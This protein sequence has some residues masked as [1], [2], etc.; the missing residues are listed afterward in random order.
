MKT[1]LRKSAFLTIVLFI[2]NMV[3]ANAAFGQATV[4]T[5]LL[6]YPP[7]S[8]AIITGS[9][10]K[11]GEA[12][13]LLVEHVGEE[14]TGTDPQYHQPWTVVADS[15]GKIE[16]SWY[17]PTVAEGDALGATF[18][19]TA[20]GAT[21]SLHA[22]WTFTDGVN[23]PYYSVVI[24]PIVGSVGVNNNYILTISNLTGGTQNGVI[25][26]IRIAIPAGVGVPIITS[27]TA[28]DPGPINRS[29]NW[30]LTQ[31][32]TLLEFK[33]SASGGGAS[34]NDI[35]PGGTIVISFS[36]TATT[37]GSKAWSTT[38]YRGNNF[39]NSGLLSGSQPIVTVC[40]PVNAVGVIAGA[41]IFCPN[42]TGVAYSISAVSGA[43]NYIWTVPAGA[44]VTSGQGTTSITVNFGTTS[45]N[46]SVTPSNVCVSG[47]SNSK[48]VTL[49]NV[50][51]TIA[52]LTGISVN[53]DAGVCSYA[54][55]QLTKPTAADNCSVLSVVASPASLV[56]GSNTVT[57]TV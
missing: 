12:V 36:T 4:S 29:S 7:G 30:S 33:N 20:D 21:S 6:D 27:I 41:T 37:V 53:A 57:W 2:A 3:F 31:T 10:F 11:A 25:G 22:E 18:L 35:D 45:G 17:V 42:Q 40:S 15:I 54:S 8:T 19:L 44:T 14:P 5:D 55:S 1:F 34:A 23:D 52:T 47:T 46:V 49:D 13:T 51:P 50:N 39:T 48:T 28:N 24:T 32:S 26:S 16:T 43:T 56:L 9:G 38:A